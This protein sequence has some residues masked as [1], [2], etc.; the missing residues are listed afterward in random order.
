MIKNIKEN[1]PDVELIAMLE[2]L[3]EQAKS[4]RLNTVVLIRGYDDGCF[5]HSWLINKH[6]KRI[7]LVGAVQ[8]M[9]YDLTTNTGLYFGD[10]ELAEALKE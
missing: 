1:V 6:C 8:M 9:N 2:K 5:A 4:G 10:S 7:S 3:L